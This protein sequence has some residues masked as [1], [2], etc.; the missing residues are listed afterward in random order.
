MLDKNKALN[1]WEKL[2]I[3]LCEMPETKNSPEMVAAIAKL[4]NVTKNL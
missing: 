2:I 4:L 1:A 3:E